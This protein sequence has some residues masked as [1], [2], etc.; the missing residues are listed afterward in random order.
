MKRLLPIIGA[1]AVVCQAAA[2]TTAQTAPATDAAKSTARPIA[3]VPATQ[4]FDMMMD[5]LKDDDYQA[6]IS[7]GTPTFQ[8]A[9]SK[10]L[11]E[12]VAAQVGPREREG[13]KATYLDSLKK[14][15]LTVYLWKIEFK[16]GD[17]TL[18]QMTL[19]NGKVA[20]FFLA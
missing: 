4:N 2:P 11:F 18:A 6:F 5:A 7:M 17:D 1:L 3:P 9:L 12:T 20:G 15:G 16:T 10:T 13:F 14:G 8:H 19:D